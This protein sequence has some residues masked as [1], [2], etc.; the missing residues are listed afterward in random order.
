MPRMTNDQ[1]IT[2]IYSDL[3][4]ATNYANTQL[5]Q[6]RKHSWDRHLARPRGDE[7][8]SR[9]KL[10]D[11]TI[12][13]TTE[14]IMAIIS[15]SWDCDNICDFAPE[16]PDDADQADAE[17]RSLNMLFHMDNNGYLE[18][19]T[20]AKNALMF[21]NGILKVWL[22]DT[23][24]VEMRTFRDAAALAAIPE[25]RILAQEETEQGVRVTIE[26]PQQRLRFKAIEPAQF[27]V[28]P[29]QDDNDMQAATFC[30]ERTFFSRSELQEM[31]ISKKL[32]KELPASPDEAI[33]DGVGSSNTDILAKFID[34]Q[35]DIK[36][37]ATKDQD[38]IE[39]YW[40]YMLMDR[41]GDGIS[42]RWRFLVAHRH[43]LLD[44][45]VAYVPYS[46]GSPWIV[47]N[48]W[49]GLGVYDKLLQVENART[50]ALRQMADNMNT[51]NN[52][53]PIADPGAINFADLLNGGPGRPVRKI[54]ADAT[55]DFMP[56][57]DMISNS[58][59]F[60]D[61]TDKMR[62][63]QA[64]SSLDMQ[65]ADSQ[66]VKSISGLSAEMQLGP[67]EQ[68]T[69][70]VQRN[71]ANTLLANA[72]LI[73]HKV[74]RE[75]WEGPLMFYK[76]GEWQQTIP[77]EW[78]PRTRINLNLAMS[79]GEARRKIAALDQVIQ[80]NFMLIQGG[81][82]NIAAT[83]G[84]VHKAITDKMRLQHLDDTEGYFI[85]PD[86]SQ[87]REAMQA[88]AEQQQGQAQM[89]QQIMGMQMQLE[90]MRVAIE[91]KKVEY[92][93]VDDEF[94]NE[95]DRLKLAQEAEIEEAKLVTTAIAGQRG[96]AEGANGQSER[97]GGSAN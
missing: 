44:D 71:L 31:G 36:E 16:G 49:S 30:S 68:M 86:S 87:A 56:V 2:A 43:L 66:S 79:P 33:T 65:S 19:Q 7:L 73:A 85:D 23:P 81:A 1:V 80:T 77:S 8:P 76:A 84:T 74:L 13:D 60:L 63:E 83:W 93:R 97:S 50:N 94:D 28:D 35:I 47:P 64:G 82:A 4:N 6:I 69:G 95:T 40:V 46:T 27:F 91:D 96:E 10:L 9:S 70:M 61:Y 58:L 53:R 5:R 37:A 42:E 59:G 34:G 88:A 54:T 3:Q 22:D 17:G 89:Q 55:V 72:F 39:C 45:P 52:Q 92:D 38:Q 67:A 21:R 25:D 18:A 15:E 32:V 62:S 24:M 11:T 29:N 90:Q 48:R 12:A 57:M 78:R 41:D 51:I 26:V 20:A 14:S 75:E